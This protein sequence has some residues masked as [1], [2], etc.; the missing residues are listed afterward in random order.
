MFISLLIPVFRT[1]SI[2]LS[3]LLLWTRPSHR[4]SLAPFSLAG[5]SCAKSA[6][7]IGTASADTNRRVSSFFTMRL[8][9]YHR[10]DLVSARTIDLR[11]GKNNP[12]PESSTGE[13]AA[14]LRKK[15]WRQPS[16]VPLTYRRPDWRPGP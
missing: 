13:G 8:S 2:D 5:A 16:G 10:K 15:V 9:P 11:T 3:G 7:D 1:V 12:F 6:V 4:T 14:P